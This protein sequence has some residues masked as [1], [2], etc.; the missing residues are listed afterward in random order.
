MVFEKP[1][2]DIEV[3]RF[4]PERRDPRGHKNGFGFALTQVDAL[5]AR[6]AIV[7]EPH[8]FI[9]AAERNFP[10]LKVFDPIECD[11]DLIAR[12]RRLDSPPESPSSP[13]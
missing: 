13:T 8:E 9:P 3:S 6:L 5:V 12:Y 11:Q 7:R 2:P 4:W 1:R 10:L